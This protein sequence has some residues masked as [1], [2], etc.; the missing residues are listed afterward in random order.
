MAKTRDYKK[1]VVEE[2]I[3]CKVCSKL[4]TKTSYQ[5]LYCS[6]VCRKQELNA[7]RRNKSFV[8]VCECCEV[9]FSSSTTKRRFCT[10]QCKGKYKYKTGEV[11]TETQYAKISGDWGRYLSRLL[12]CS[13]RKRDGLTRQDLLTILEKQDH[14]CAISGLPLTCTLKKGTKFWTNA[15]IDRVDAGGSYEPHN[16]QLVCRAVNSWR[17]DLPLETFI[18]VCRAVARH[19]T[20]EIG[21]KDGQA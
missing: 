18:E 9:T 19:N 1:V 6:E 13:G 15:S 3:S 11:T 8:K 4:F 7:R 5:C 16:I 10:P 12:Y 14:L 20:G 17:S 2:E 21:G